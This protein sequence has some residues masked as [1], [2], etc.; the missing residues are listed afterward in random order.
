[1]KKWILVFVL[2]LLI[3]FLCACGSKTESADTSNTGSAAQASN[4]AVSSKD[5]DYKIDQVFFRTFQGTDGEHFQGSFRVTNTGKTPLFLTN[6]TW[7]LKDSSG[8]VITISPQPGHPETYMNVQP[9]T[10][11]YPQVLYEGETSWYYINTLTEKMTDGSA[12]IANASPVYRITDLNESIITSFRKYQV[13]D[14]R[15]EE[16]GGTFTACGTVENNTDEGSNYILIYVNLYDK[17]GRLVGQLKAYSNP[18][19]PGEKQSFIAEQ[20]S[21]WSSGELSLDFSS[22]ANI[23]AEAFFLKA[24]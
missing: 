8:R 17:D 21:S 22:I 10:M 18:L 1:M 2:I 20:D 7:D 3:A 12:D 23:D 4:S 14:L 19:S 15:L 11:A 6:A 24:S 16:N 5:M 9:A 13:T